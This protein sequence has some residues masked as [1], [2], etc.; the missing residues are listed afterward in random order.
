MPSIRLSRT[1]GLDWPQSSN[2]GPAPLLAA[3][4]KTGKW[5][6]GAR[7]DGRA[8]V[9]PRL[10]ERLAVARKTIRQD[11]DAHGNESL[12]VAQ[13]AGKAADDIEKVQSEL[14]TLQHDASELHMAIDPVSSKIVPAENM[15]PMEAEIAEMQLQ[16]RLDKI[17][18][19]ANAVDAEL[20][21]QLHRVAELVA[22]GKS[23]DAGAAV[24]KVDARYGGLAAPQSVELA[25]R[26]GAQ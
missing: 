20:A 19:E 7:L 26:A 2:A 12:A 8:M 1:T 21:A 14:R 15:P 17:L 5:Q 22:A 13:A 10:V 24:R 6:R 18:A 23:A 4:S 25:D 9:R 11:L 3:F 16:P